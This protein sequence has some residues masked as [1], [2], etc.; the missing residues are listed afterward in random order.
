MKIITINLPERYLKAIKTLKDMGIYP[1][2]S[3]AVRTAL[4][5]FL[6]EEVKFFD[7]IKQNNLDVIIRSS[8]K[9]RKSTGWDN[10]GRRFY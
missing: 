5:G 3:E 8:L 1:S 7:E 6:E 4:D 2:R 9:N 10:N